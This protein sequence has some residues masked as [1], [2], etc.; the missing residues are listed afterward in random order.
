MFASTFKELIDEFITSMRIEFGISMVGEL[1]FFLRL[2][3]KQM[4]EGIF[5]SQ[6]NYARNLVKKYGIESGKRLRTTMS[7]TLKINKD[8]QGKSVDQYEYKSMI[9][10]FLYL[11]AKLPDI[12]Y[13]V[14]CARYQSNPKK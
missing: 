3:I 11:T 7:T 6:A 14:V 4:K 5:L 8:E 13:S 12:S 9:G 2:H 10:G 1:T